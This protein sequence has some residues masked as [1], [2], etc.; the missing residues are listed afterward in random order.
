MTLP[1]LPTTVALA[2]VATLGYL[3]GRRSRGGEPPSEHAYRDLRQTL[4]DARQLE[5]L[6]DDMLQATRQALDECRRLSFGS[7]T[8]ESKAG[9]AR[10]SHGSNGKSAFENK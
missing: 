4:D 2:A 7:R 5:Q 1:F 9:P 3:V 6:T 10:R 8:D